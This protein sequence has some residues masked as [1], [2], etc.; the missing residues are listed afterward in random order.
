MVLKR[1]PSGQKRKGGGH[2]LGGDGDGGGGGMNA[3][4]G[5]PY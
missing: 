4:V 2:R 3:A 5:R 1:A